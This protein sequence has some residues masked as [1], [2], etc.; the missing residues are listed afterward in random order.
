MCDSLWQ[1][2][3]V[4]SVVLIQ[5][6][7]CTILMGDVALKV[8]QV[9]WICDN[10]STFDLTAEVYSVSMQKGEGRKNRSLPF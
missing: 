9:S 1:Q 7:E 10:F 3:D 4:L 2:L 6:C 8:H 5:Y